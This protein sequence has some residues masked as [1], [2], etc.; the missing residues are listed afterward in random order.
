LFEAPYSLV[1][2]G[3]FNIHV[4]VAM[5]VNHS[6]TPPLFPQVVPR[7]HTLISCILV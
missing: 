2:P 4:G 7:Q 6:Q 5:A 1:P 3:V